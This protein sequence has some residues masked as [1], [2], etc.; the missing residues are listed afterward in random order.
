MLNGLGLHVMPFAS[1]AT[2]NHMADTFDD[3]A[4]DSKHAMNARIDRLL[5]AL[6]P[7]ASKETSIP[8]NL[9]CDCSTLRLPI[10]HQPPVL[11][12]SDRAA[13]MQR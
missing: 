10:A 2:K 11:C 12:P 13:A 9:L 8:C 4:P 7:I 1:G 6:E 3:N 5:G